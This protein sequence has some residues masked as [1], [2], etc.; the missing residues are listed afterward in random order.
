MKIDLVENAFSM[1]AKHELQLTKE[2]VEKVETLGQN[3]LRT[4]AKAMDVH[5]LLL[6]VQEHF[7]AELIKNVEIFQDDCTNF[8][9]SYHTKGPMEI[10]LSPKAASD[11]L[12]A[13]QNQFDTLWRK[14]SSYSVGED[15]FGLPHTDQSELEGIKK[16]LNLLQRL[17]NLYNNVI[18]SI[19][20]YESIL[21]KAVDIEEIGNELMEYQNRCRK[22]PK[23]LKEW[24]AF[25]ALKKM[26]DDFSELCPILEL[27]SNK[28]MK[29]RHWQRIENITGFK[30]DIDR[31]GFQLKDIMQAPLLPNKED[32]EDICISAIKEKDIEAKLKGVIAEWST[33]EIEFLTF[34][35]RGELLLRGD[36]TAESVNQVEDSL[37]ILGSLLSNRYNAPFKKQIQKWVQDLSNTNEVLERWLLV[38]NLWVYL[39]A[40]FV[41]GDIAKQ[42]PKEAKRF[43]RIDKTWQKIMQRAHDTPSVV[44]CCVG[45]DFLK[46][47]LPNLQE[48]LELCQKSLTG[49]LEKKRLMFPRFFFVSD[50]AL[51][52]ILGQASDSHTIQAHLLSIFDNTAQVKFDPSDYNKIVSIISKEGEIVQ[53]D[54]PVRAEGSVEIWLMSLLVAAKDSVNSI[55]RNAFHIISDTNFD[56][57][58]F[59]IKY[60]AQVGILGIQMI[61]TREAESALQNCRL[62]KKIM[63][64][65]NNKFLEML[66]TLIGQTVKNLTKIERTKYE[67]LITVHMHQRDIFD[68][69]V[70]L[71]VKSTQDFEWLKQARFYFKADEE[72]CAISITDVTF[73]YQNEFIG[74]QERLV[75]TP[76]TDRYL[77]LV[78]YEVCLFFNSI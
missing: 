19:T 34:K 18:D 38:Q 36:T 28:A 42:L 32:I 67:T 69:L 50:P 5:L 16:E 25:H 73:I 64:E 40:V 45:D 21:W 11:R 59:V 7:K 2:D 71:N 77:V 37:M 66:N 46:Q 51:L 76:L 39:E 78:N 57:L 72:K 30:F 55:I 60:Q 12:E 29:Y 48:Q 15:M 56:M 53:L 70:R 20:G 33:Q 41:G 10:G 68:M 47:T 27:M 74:C 23:G 1:M 17:Y 8:V 31:T 75:I 13:F 14:H 43:Y 44:N 35:N 52:E 62:D 4:Q 9:D 24:P 3:W 61:W 58:D 65:T 49:Y 63:S 54:R 6:E 26:I 22:L